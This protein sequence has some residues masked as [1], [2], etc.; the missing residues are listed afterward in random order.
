MKKYFLA[1]LI[2]LGACI[3]LVFFQVAHA[4]TYYPS[5]AYNVSIGTTAAAS[6]PLNKTTDSVRLVC[7][8]DCYV[9]LESSSAAAFAAVSAYVL[10]PADWPI[11]LKSLGSTYVLVSAGSS[12]IL[13]ITE[14]SK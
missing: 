5:T 13:N 8:V 9:A 12:G 4:D 2:S 7:T 10:L 11:T 1:L 14:M 3:T 6:Q